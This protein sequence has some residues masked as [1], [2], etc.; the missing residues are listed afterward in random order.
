MSFIAGAL[1]SAGTYL[2][3]KAMSTGKEMNRDNLITQKE[4]EE[5]KA[6]SK[7]FHEL[8]EYSKYKLDKAYN[9]EMEMINFHKQSLELAHYNIQNCL[10]AVEKLEDTNLNKLEYYRDALSRAYEDL[11]NLRIKNLDYFNEKLL[12][13]NK[14]G[15]VDF[16]NSTEI[17][18][19][20]SKKD[21]EEP[22]LIE[23]ISKIPL[24]K[25]R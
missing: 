12:E 5:I 11:R 24:P 23:V 22:S 18:T 6:K 20:E 2:I 17:G 19:R 25:K 16:H 14:I 21:K 9:L 7:A 13:N 4:M 1:I 3:G 15:M 8:I 10:K